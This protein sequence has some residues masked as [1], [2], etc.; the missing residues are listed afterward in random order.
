MSEES[1]DIGA[2]IVMAAI[3]ICVPLLFIIAAL[4]SIADALTK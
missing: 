4:E 1:R 3:L 2:S